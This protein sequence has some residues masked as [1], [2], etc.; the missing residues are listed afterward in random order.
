MFRNP[1]SI[2]SHATRHF[3]REPSSETSR[4]LAIATSLG[5]WAAS[6]P[7]EGRLAG[8]KNLAACFTA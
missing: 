1:E 7:L 2:A 5:R 3:W 6:Q 4:P 8:F